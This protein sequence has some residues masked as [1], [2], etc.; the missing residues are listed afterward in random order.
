MKRSQREENVVFGLDIG[1]R[2]VVGTVGYMMDDK[3]YVVAQRVKAHETRAMLDGQI[4]DIGKVSST[5]RT[6][7]Q[8]L[9]TETGI[10]LTEVCIAAAGR[11]LRTV[12]ASYEEEYEEEKNITEEDIYN[13]ESKAVEKAYAEFLNDE[14]REEKFFL[15]GYT[16][17][18]YYMNGY[19]I[20]NLEGHTVE[21]VALDLIATFLPQDVV[22]GLYRACERAGLTVANLTLEPIAA[23]RVA[24]PE[25][26]RMLN[27]ALIDVGAGTSDI[28]VTDEGTIIA[29]GMIPEAGD[30]LT[31]TIAQKCLVDFNTADQI[32]IDASHMDT[33]TYYDIMGLE[34]KITNKEVQEMLKPQV[35]AMADHVTEMIKQLNGDSPVQAVFVVGGGGRIPGYTEAIA[36]RMEIADERVALRGEEVMKNIVFPQDDGIEHDSLIVTPIGICLSYYAESN[37]FVFVSFNGQQ[38][39]IYDNGRLAIVDAA[40]QAEFPN[41]DLFPKRGKE[42][43]FTVNGEKRTVRGTPGEAAVI[44][45]NGKPA[46]IHSRI[47]KGDIIEVDPS[48]TGDPGKAQ[49]ASLAEYVSKFNVNVNGKNVSVSRFA[50]VDG[51]PQ[52][53]LYDIRQ[54]DEVKVLDYDTAQ[55]IAQLLDIE[56]TEDSVIYVNNEKATPDTPV[57][58]NFKVEFKSADEVIMDAYADLPDAEE[59]AEQIEEG[60]YEEET[61][62]TAEEAPAP[63]PA[64]APTAAGTAGSYKDL[65]ADEEEEEEEEY[66]PPKRT[67][68][69]VRPPGAGFAKQE[70]ARPMHVTVNNQPII[71]NGKAEYVFVDVF[72]YIDF[73]L[74]KPQGAIVTLLNGNVP[75]YMQK[76]NA[77]DKIEVYWQK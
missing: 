35:E 40:M 6:I 43:S 41:E 63:A 54:G 75:D 14:K 4:H 16:V 67:A 60:T 44:R 74:S 15:V 31:E 65:Y 25:S 50:T 59:V 26:Y 36:K 1:T 72:D 27:L 33:V 46:D 11:V 7:K 3:F 68:G 47:R 2:S 55:Q 77:N 48:T 10:E 23:I 34:K 56:L 9:E 24:I 53:S 37:N 45:L 62:G 70:I 61:E 30:H 17:K 38:T 8:E 39:K 51:K 13:I 32:K 57:Y 29:Y 21:K 12:Q 42:L 52:T 5:I 20:V 76:L 49:I 22:D 18:H 66:V 69:G 64:P 71:L 58:E 19:K 73:D 28:C